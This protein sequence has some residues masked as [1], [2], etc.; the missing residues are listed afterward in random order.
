MLA[1]YLSLAE[2]YWKASAGDTVRNSLSLAKSPLRSLSTAKYPS[3]L[4]SG[5]WLRTRRLGISASLLFRIS[6]NSKMFPILWDKG[7]AVL[8]LLTICRDM[9]LFKYYLCLNCLEPNE[10]RTHHRGRQLSL[11]DGTTVES[12][13]VCANDSRPTT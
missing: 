9:E 5:L 10:R 1:I 7:R 2:T 12:P 6:I 4:V 11:T 3:A 13:A 8:E